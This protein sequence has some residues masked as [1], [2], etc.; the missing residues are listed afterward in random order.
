MKQQLTLQ[1][2]RNIDLFLFALM[3][4]IFEFV[5]VFFT[6][7]TVYHISL[8]AVITAIIYMR[9]GWWGA[10]HAALAGVLF[11]FYF[12]FVAP[13]GQG[14]GLEQYIIYPVGNLFSL[15]CVPVLK[16]LGQERVRKD[17][18]LS[19]LFSLSVILLMQG[20][21]AVVGLVLSVVNTPLAP[22]WPNLL[23]GATASFT[24]DALSI[25]F[26]LV[27]TWIV[28]RL[29]GVFEEQKHYLR[30]IQEEQEQSNSEQ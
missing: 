13:A 4:A 22:D 11:C 21:R 5:I 29:D 28:R 30:R 14:P 10:I 24:G 17:T 16:K 18:L 12:S 7:F 19:L 9:W 27:V 8:A 25:L 23:S 6:S 3:L 2:Y 26:T 1:Q 20:G 15:L